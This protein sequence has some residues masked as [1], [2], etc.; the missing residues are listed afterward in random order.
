M[1][2]PHGRPWTSEAIDYIMLSAISSSP[3]QL[4][5]LPAKSGL[6]EADKR[7]IKKWLDWGRTHAAYLMVRQDLPD[8]PQAGKIDG[9]AHLLGDHGYLFLFNPNPEAQPANF[10]LDESIGLTQGTSFSITAEYPDSKLKTGLSRGSP[11][12]WIIPPRTATI[13]SIKPD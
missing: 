1:G 13:L 9:S 7:E 8:W 5:Y 3:N 11:V 12:S 10:S 4:Y 6:P 2:P